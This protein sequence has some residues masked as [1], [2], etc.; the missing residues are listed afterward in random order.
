MDFALTP[1]QETIRAKFNDYLDK[2]L[3]PRASDRV[4]E[5]S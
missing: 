4:G 1:E 3:T 2:H 5:V